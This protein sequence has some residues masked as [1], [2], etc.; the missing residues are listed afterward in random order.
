MSAPCVLSP[1]NTP[2]FREICRGSRRRRA[3]LFD[4][5]DAKAQCV[6]LP[7]SNHDS[8]RTFDLMSGWSGLRWYEVI[9]VRLDR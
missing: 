1:P 8:A 2:R 3:T 6:G 5:T 4:S 7:A 9:L